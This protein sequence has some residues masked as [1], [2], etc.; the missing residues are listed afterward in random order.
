[1]LITHDRFL[2]D[3]LSDQLLFL[4][5]KGHAEFF[6]DYAQW[7]QS[8]SVQSSPPAP[9]PETAARK[10]ISYEEQKELSRLPEKIQKAEA[11]LETLQN[12]LTDPAIMNDPKRLTEHCQRIE[13]AT[14]KVNQLY[15][16]WQQ[17]EES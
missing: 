7:R 4:D 3:R 11:E 15:Q 16:R 8:L 14:A 10:K 1:M 17:L 13:A 5:G 6:A 2:L 12:Q 9:K